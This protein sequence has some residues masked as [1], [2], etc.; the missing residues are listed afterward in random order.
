MI[1]HLLCQTIFKVLL[2]DDDFQPA[3]WIQVR[4]V[5]YC[6][7]QYL[8]HIFKQAD[9]KMSKNYQVLLPGLPGFGLG[10]PS[11]LVQV[12]SHLAFSKKLKA[13]GASF[14]KEED[15]RRPGGRAEGEQGTGSRLEEVRTLLKRQSD[16]KPQISII[17]DLYLDV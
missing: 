16:F 5:R 17:L 11:Q 7:V 9:F 12:C 1:C 15:L 6:Q 8:T 2:C 4:W 13:I 14:S 3:G 10:F